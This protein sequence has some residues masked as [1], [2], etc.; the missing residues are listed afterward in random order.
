ME[1][2]SADNDWSNTCESKPAAAAESTHVGIASRALAIWLVI[3]VAENLHGITRGIFLVPHVGQFRSSQ[4]GVFT[5]SIIIQAVAV[6]FVRWIGA[7]RPAQL[8]VV[9]LIWL[10]LTLAFEVL[11]GRFVIGASW[12]RLATDYNVLEGGLLPFG[13]VVLLLSPLIA[14]LRP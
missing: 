13:M 10:C 12:E 9:G 8:L 14:A 5:G 2:N 3:L 6:V 7:T 4:I 1:P 11:F